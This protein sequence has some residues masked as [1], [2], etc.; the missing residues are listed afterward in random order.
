MA[1]QPVQFV[2]ELRLFFVVKGV[3]HGAQNILIEP[4]ALRWYVLDGLFEAF[5]KERVTP[6]ILP[7][8]F[9]KRLECT[10]ANISYGRVI[11]TMLSARCRV[12]EI[13]YGNRDIV[14]KGHLY[15]VLDPLWGNRDI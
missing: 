2:I 15:G 3:V 1:E 7:G 14:L 11:S 6:G 12:I 5:R 8:N 10:G 9:D 13:W 4:F